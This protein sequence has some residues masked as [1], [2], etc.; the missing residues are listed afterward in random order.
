MTAPDIADFLSKIVQEFELLQRLAVS[1]RIR[2]NG[3]RVSLSHCVS[4]EASA[5]ILA[6]NS[7]IADLKVADI[8]NQNLRGGGKP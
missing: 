4:A 5:A 3:K 6:V 2:L 8:G 7:F 1:P